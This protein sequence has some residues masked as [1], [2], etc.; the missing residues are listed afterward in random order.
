[1]KS[2]DLA[3]PVYLDT[4]MLLDLLASIE[5]G[6]SMVEKITTRSADSKTTEL[7]GGTEFGIANVLNLLKID[8]KGAAART[9][10]QQTGEERQAERYH[11]YGSLLYRLRSNLGESGLVKEII[12]DKSWQDIATSDFVE[13]QGK[14]VPNPLRASLQTLNRLIGMALL[15]GGIDLASES[16]SPQERKKSKNEARQFQATQ[17]FF[18]GIMKDLEHES[19]ETYVIE[20]VSLPSHRIVVSLFIEYIRDRSGSELPYGEFRVLGKVVR[21]IEK[22]D[23]IDLLR[24]SALSGVS[25]T[26]LSQFLQPFQEMGEQG[27]KIPDISTKVEAPAMQIIPIAV[28]I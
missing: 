11:T 12:D 19:M 27:L 14:F 4:N 16:K 13:L 3:I 18:E 1:M 6:F 10:G 2:S 7:S 22:E 20:S 26:M 15:F 21:K 28:Y 9:K 8:L 5:G 17:K 25:E 23:T 24:G